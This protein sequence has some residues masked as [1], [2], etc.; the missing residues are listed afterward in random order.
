[1]FVKSTVKYIQSL[2]HKK[3][4]DA[5]RVFIAEGPKL[6]EELLSGNSVVPKEI[7]AT[8][9]WAAI[10]SK[11]KEIISVID[12]HSLAR[13]SSLVTPNQVLAIFNQPVFQSA[14]QPG[15]EIA[16]ILDS[17]QDP[18]NLGT[19]IRTAD[20]FGIDHIFCSL[21]TADQFNPKVVQSTMGSISRVQVQYT[22][23]P[24]FIDQYSGEPL[25]AATLDGR[26]LP[27]VKTPTHGFL[28]VGN[29]SKGVSK[30]LLVK[31]STRIRIPGK[32]RAES[33]NASVATAIILAAWIR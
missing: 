26:D 5:D 30:E 24:A 32:G 2:S 3:Q 29:E 22:D 27:Q 23:L 12:D 14:F 33:L 21:E 8:S 18:G 28:L 19:I 10:H 20:W 16:L 1:M 9:E 17:I 7:F 4:R 6:V 13:I 15:K 11:Y 31:A 25:F